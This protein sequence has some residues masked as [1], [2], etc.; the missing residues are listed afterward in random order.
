[1]S[2]K[3]SKKS[4]PLPS[5]AGVERL[6]PLGEIVTTHG[7]DGWF[8]FNA[9]NAQT[10]ALSASQQIFLEK[11]G[12]RSA[13][14]L[15]AS[16]RHRGQFLIKLLGI[17]HLGDADRCVGSTLLVAEEALQ[18]LAAG[19]YYHYQVIGL[20][21]FDVRG[22]RIGTVTRTW[23]TAGGELYVVAGESKEHLI[24]AVKDIIEK[25]DLIARRIVINP[26]AGLLDL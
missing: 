2:W 8:K 6:I 15:E 5:H 7:L 26:P 16:R 11:A 9:Y 12:V 21:V 25:V 4:N 17:D 1:L 23:A 3:F 10:A 13:H 19:E 20:E 24:P 14:Q 22:E 18:S